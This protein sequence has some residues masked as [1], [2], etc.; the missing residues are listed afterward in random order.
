M[1]SGC[2]NDP[3]IRLAFNSSL[4]TETQKVESFLC[5]EQTFYEC[6]IASLERYIAFCVMF[7]A[8]AVQC[9]KPM[10]RVPWDIAR[11]QSN[12]RV[13]TTASPVSAVDCGGSNSQHTQSTGVKQLVHTFA[14]KISKC[15][16]N[17]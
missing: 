2:S 15:K 12:L 13:A 17:F 8:M 9:H 16:F 11:S 7:H 1:L 10:F 5:N 6:R 3:N 4:D 14:S